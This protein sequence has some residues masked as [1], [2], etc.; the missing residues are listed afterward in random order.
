MAGSDK[1]DKDSRAKRP[2]RGTV[3]AEVAALTRQRVL[4]AALAL[5]AEEWLDRLTLDQVATGAGVTV[6]TII[7]HFGSKEGLFTAAAEA[8]TAAALGWREETP[9]GD[10]A[11]AVEALQAHYERTGDRLLR[12]LAQEDRYPGLRRLTD[13]GRDAHRAWVARIFGVELPQLRGRERDR[14]LAEL[15][16]VTDITMWKLLRRDLRLD[17]EQTSLA[18]GEMVTALLAPVM[19]GHE[20]KKDD[21]EDQEEPRERGEGAK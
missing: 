4:D 7:R 12:L 9:P 1:R 16:A 15:V 3:Q 8:A 20:G 17:R 6:Q 11:S 13:L 19:R 18:V 14:L 21:E 10:I 2:Y 5:A